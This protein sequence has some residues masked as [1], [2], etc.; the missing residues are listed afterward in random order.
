LLGVVHAVN[1]L[2]LG[3]GLGQR[4]QKQRRQNGNNSDD[5]QQ[6]DQ[7]ERATGP[8]RHFA[9]AP[10]R[11]NGHQ[12]RCWRVLSHNIV[13]RLLAYLHILGNCAFVR[14]PQGVPPG[15]HFAL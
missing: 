9:A 1:A 13:A 4:G 10:L 11:A 8:G 15:P 2:G 3:L 14:T 7:G 12:K 5:H 6:L